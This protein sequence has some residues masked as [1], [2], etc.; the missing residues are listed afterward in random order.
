MNQIARIATSSNP[1]A[2]IVASQRTPMF[3]ID[4]SSDFLV[5]LEADF[6]DFEKQPGSGL[7]AL[8]CAM[9]ANHMYEWVWGDWLKTDHDVWKAS[10][11]VMTKPSS[12]DR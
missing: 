10:T 8:N 7:L 5:K 6:A 12:L 9:T 11:F 4:T 2:R 3:G 1:P